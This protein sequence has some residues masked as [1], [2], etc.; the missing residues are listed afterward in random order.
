MCLKR[1]RSIKAGREVLDLFPSNVTVGDHAFWESVLR[2]AAEQAGPRAAWFLLYPRSRGEVPVL[3]ALDDFEMTYHVLRGNLI[4]S[5]PC[6]STAVLARLLS[7]ELLYF[8]PFVYLLA[9][10]EASSDNILLPYFF[11][12]SPWRWLLRH[13][14]GVVCQL[15]P[16]DPGCLIAVRKGG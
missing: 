3:S 15:S 10:D 6:L 11:C 7:P 2:I 1:K 16:R 4:V 12:C 5:L 9:T 8:T 13:W 14:G